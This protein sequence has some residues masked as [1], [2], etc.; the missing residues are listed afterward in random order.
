M[1]HVEGEGLALNQ[2]V[3]VPDFC[4]VG[5]KFPVQGEVLS[6]CLIELP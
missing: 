3:E 4:H 5:Q 6:L 2:A 1:V